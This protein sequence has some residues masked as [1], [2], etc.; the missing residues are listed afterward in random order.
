MSVTL[1]AQLLTMHVEHEHVCIVAHVEH[2]LSTVSSYVVVVRV[3]DM[4]VL[5]KRFAYVYAFERDGRYIIII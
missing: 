1:Y 2:A 5:L 4:I 3:V